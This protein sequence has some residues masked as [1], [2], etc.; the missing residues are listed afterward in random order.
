MLTPIQ[1]RGTSLSDTKQK[2]NIEKE[3]GT[4]KQELLDIIKK[5]WK[6][7]VSN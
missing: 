6:R 2:N 1:S 5:N 3:A 7:I 4:G